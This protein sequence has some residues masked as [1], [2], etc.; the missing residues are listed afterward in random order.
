[1]EEQEEE[2]EEE[3]D[4]GQEEKEGAQEGDEDEG[5][6]PEG[7]HQLLEQKQLGDTHAS[8]PGAS[9]PF[10]PTVSLPTIA[11]LS[12]ALAKI[13]E[14]VLGVSINL[15]SP[16]FLSREH[17]SDSTSTQCQGRGALAIAKPRCWRRERRGQPHWHRLGGDSLL[18]LR[19]CKTLRDTLVSTQFGISKTLFEINQISNSYFHRQQLTNNHLSHYQLCARAS[20]AA[21]MVA[22][23]A[24]TSATIAASTTTVTAS[25][26][27]QHAERDT[28]IQA[29]VC[30]PVTISH[31][32]LFGTSATFPFTACMHACT[33]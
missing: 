3:K 26:T 19:V 16:P 23:A 9:T 7:L 22:L 2:E 20:A 6:G 24:A 18:A 13:W 1:M 27:K 30:H 5:G 12:F 31:L 29:L 33:A 32:L 10:T 15:P 21:S 28:Q 17:S 14:R 11:L 25:V 4:S 8:M